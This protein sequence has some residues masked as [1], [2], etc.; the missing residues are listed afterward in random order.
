MGIVR[1]GS[2]FECTDCGKR[3]RGANDCED[4][5]PPKR[6][7]KPKASKAIEQAAEDSQAE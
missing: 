2:N 4:C 6:K 3:W 7:R 1:N 5:A